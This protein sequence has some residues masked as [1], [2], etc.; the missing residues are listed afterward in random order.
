MKKIAI[1]I[2]I[3]V[4]AFLYHPFT[5]T[6]AEPNITITVNET[7]LVLHIPPVIVDGTTLVPFRPLMERLG[8]QVEWDEESRTIQATRHELKLELQLGQATAVINDEPVPLD[9][10]PRLIEASTFVPLRFIAE[11]TGNQ[12]EWNPGAKSITIRGPE[13]VKFVQHFGNGSFVPDQVPDR[14]AAIDVFEA[15]DMLHIVWCSID[16]ESWTFNVYLSAGKYDEW[17]VREKVVLQLPVYESEM[18]SNHP[19]VLLWG[20]A[21]YYDDVEGLK[22]VMFNEKGDIDSSETIIQLPRAKDTVRP[23]HKV[24]SDKKEGILWATE[25]GFQLYFLDDLKKPIDVAIHPFSEPSL[26]YSWNDPLFLDPTHT[27]LTLKTG[28]FGGALVR[29][30]LPTRA[31]VQDDTKKVH[32]QYGLAP[33]G[34]KLVGG[35]LILHKGK[36]YSFYTTNHRAQDT[37]NLAVLDP[38]NLDIQ[39]NYLNLTSIHAIATITGNEMHL[40]QMESDSGILDLVVFRLP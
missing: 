11:A 16:K 1:A 20:N 7:P 28:I 34:I 27:Y 8:L 40:W 19:P 36:L 37:F 26:A 22:R 30:H 14:A 9:A 24:I 31:F 15:K 12:V 35:Q 29:Y 17:I 3:S 38:V 32:K 2:G 39:E 13:W 25:T 18:A 33:D 4:L 23:L 6:A 10:A 5:T 21:I